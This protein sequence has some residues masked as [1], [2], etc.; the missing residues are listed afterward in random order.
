[1]KDRDGGGGWVSITII[2]DVTLERG[3][4]KVKRGHVWGEVFEDR[5]A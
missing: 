2:K 4:K 3:L 1:M 5:A